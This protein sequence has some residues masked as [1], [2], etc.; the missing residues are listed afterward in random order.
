MKKI[1][2]VS[3]LVLSSLLAMAEAGLKNLRGAEQELDG[4][5][6]R[7]IKYDDWG[8]IGADEGVIREVVGRILSENQGKKGLLDT[9]TKDYTEGNWEYEWDRVA[10][11]HEKKGDYE[12]AAAYYTISAY[13]YFKGSRRNHESYVIEGMRNYVRMVE[14]DGFYYEKIEVE[15]PQGEAY[16]NLHLPESSGRDYP[17][18][19]FTGGSD[20]FSVEYY[21]LFRDYL[22][23]QGIALITFELPGMGI[24]SHLTYTPDTNIIHRGVIERVKSDS[25]FNG[26]IIVGASSLGG[27]PAVRTAFTNEEDLVAV[28]NFCGALSDVWLGITPESFSYY[29]LLNQVVL[30]DRTGLEISEFAE[31]APEYSLERQGYLGK[32]KTNVPI[33]SLNTGSDPVAPK[34]DMKL[35]S[36]A[37][38]EGIT[39]VV[40]S[41]VGHGMSRSIALPIIS[42]YIVDK[43]K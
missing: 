36:E 8:Y 15:T 34:S 3:M 31:I 26:K 29:P 22:A 27:Q 4:I 30:A 23:D 40:E 10:R 41:E 32:M 20:V 5:F 35:A 16:A 39:L 13:P 21:R 18:V 17:V 11:G 9:V 42:G 38:K 19:I 43:L 37:S 1:M 33:M 28:V 6:L 14:G 12:A 7:E 25:R 2:I 24:N